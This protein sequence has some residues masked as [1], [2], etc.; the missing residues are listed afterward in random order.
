[1]IPKVE[2]CEASRSEDK[3]LILT[4]IRNTVGLDEF[5]AAV[6]EEIFQGVNMLMKE[7]TKRAVKR[8]GS[9]FVQ[10]RYHRGK[11][12]SED[13][14]P[15]SC[16]ETSVEP[17]SGGNGRYLDPRDEDKIELATNRITGE[18]VCIKTLSLK[19]VGKARIKEIVRETEILL[20]IHHTHIVHLVDAYEM[21][22]ATKISFVSEC[23]TGPKLLTQF[24]N[25]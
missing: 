20:S 16:N 22:D 3:D 10:S 17:Q 8:V 11:D 4:Q 12:V 6:S 13:Y 18:N 9:V 5:N 7:S 23:L 15:V 25:K 19:G 24:L 2:D 21:A 1:M 14:E